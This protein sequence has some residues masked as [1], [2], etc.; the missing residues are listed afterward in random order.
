[1]GRRFHKRT[2][3]TVAYLKSPSF[4]CHVGVFLVAGF[5][6]GFPFNPQEKDERIDPCCWVPVPNGRQTSDLFGDPPFYG[7]VCMANFRV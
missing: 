6:F 7:Q 2:L 5:P 4:A 3:T 1:M